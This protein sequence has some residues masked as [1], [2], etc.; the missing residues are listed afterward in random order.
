MR[1]TTLSFARRAFSDQRGQTL[2]FVA[3]GMVALLGV[4]GLTVD[5]GRAY[6]VRAQL[7][8]SANAAALAASGAVYD[9][10]SDAVNSTTIANEYG[11]GGSTDNN[12]F[13]GMGTVTTTVTTVCL[14]S[15][16]PKGT[17][18]VSGSAPNAV[19]VVNSTVVNTFLMGLFGVP[20]L[21]VNATAKASIQG[22]SQPWNVAIIIDS[23][24]SMAT[25]DS[26]CNNL[27]EFQCALTGVQAL[28]QSA[29]P[30]PS[31]V[32]SCSGS[33]A[34]LR[35]SLFTFPNVLTSYNG[36]SNN[37]LSDDINCS[38]TPATWTDYSAQP[39]AAPYTLP[40]PGATLPGTPNA[41]SMT[42]TQTS[43][44]KTWTATYQITPFLSDYYEPSAAGGLN[45][46]SNLVKAVGV[47]STKGCLT[48][49]FGI[50]GTGS[51]SGF[52]NTYL[53]GAIYEAQ[54][55]LVAEQ[56]ASAPNGGKN[57]II[58]LSDGQSN[59]S[60]YSKNTSAYGTANSTN[61]YAD[62][63]EFPSGPAGS[64]V[65]PTSTSPADPVPAYYTPATTSSY[66]Y[67]ALTGTGVYPDWKDQC[68][69]AMAAAQ[70]ATSKGTRVYSVAYGSESSGCN[71]GWNIGLTD[72]TLQSSV[73]S[74]ANVSFTLSQVTPCL[75]MENIASS[76]TYF[77]SDY[78]QSGSGSTCQDNSH[79][80]E[81]LND[82]F[83]A[84]AATFTT[85]RLLPNNAT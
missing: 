47:G 3:L 71:S 60:Y 34:N 64:E 55:A 11:S 23:T 18:C 63:Y 38:G 4:G 83:Q 68:Q 31:G 24:G 45:S 27:T 62:A 80:T 56:T 57:A 53:P 35:M 43:T 6:V 50:W 1:N 85:P 5:V 54:A 81:T 52:G 12:Y 17:S 76:L 28:L 42:Y 48:Y 77:Y 79:A 51:G 61:Q 58:I 46:S 59:A 13:S 10:Q 2:P 39:I 22:A 33:T 30:C 65:G 26:N 84:I 82:I 9:A 36:V 72:T 21:A 32:S 44:G 40:V 41:T 14:N 78:N 7:Q 20:K 16:M 74:A 70:Y 73:V 69:Q 49:T 75:S 19:K 25:T 37:S 66:G 15:L 67:S 29:I 8:N